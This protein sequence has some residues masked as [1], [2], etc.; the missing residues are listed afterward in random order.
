MLSLQVQLMFSRVK[1]SWIYLFL[2]KVWPN[3]VLQSSCHLPTSLAPPALYSHKFPL[4]GAQLIPFSL[5]KGELQWTQR[6]E[7]LSCNEPQQLQAQAPVFAFKCL[8]SKSVRWYLQQSLRELN[9]E[10]E[11]G[12]EI[13]G[14]GA[15]ELQGWWRDRGPGWPLLAVPAQH[16]QSLT[17][18]Y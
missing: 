14:K 11:E 8:C 1:I 6:N 3:V 4:P 17:L 5:C 9:T 15:A 2:A 13:P 16:L 18:N 10:G 7:N 12:E